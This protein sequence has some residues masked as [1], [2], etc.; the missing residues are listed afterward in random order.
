MADTFVVA[1]D[2]VN[3]LDSH[4]D[5]IVAHSYS[6]NR[7]VDNKIIVLSWVLRLYANVKFK[8]HYHL[9]EL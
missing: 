7:D 1:C 2:M 8:R 5:K 6:I 3:E 4:L 9:S